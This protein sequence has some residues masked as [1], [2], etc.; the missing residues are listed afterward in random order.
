MKILYCLFL[1]QTY[2]NA[3]FSCCSSKTKETPKTELTQLKHHTKSQTQ[4]SYNYNLNITNK[5][6]LLINSIYES[7]INALSSVDKQGFQQSR[8]NTNDRI[9]KY[10]LN[11]FLS[12]F[13]ETITQKEHFYQLINPNYT[14]E[15]VEYILL[16]TNTQNYAKEIYEELKK[17]EEFKELIF[18]IL[19]KDNI[20]LFILDYVK[21]TYK[22][23][24]DQESYQM[25]VNYF[26]DI[27][28]FFSKYTL[29]I[30][31]IHQTLR[32]LGIDYR[33]NDQ[34]INQFSQHFLG[35]STQDIQATCDTTSITNSINIQ[36][37]A[38]DAF[39]RTCDGYLFFMILT[40]CIYNT[41][42]TCNLEAVRHFY[43]LYK[44][45]STIAI[46]IFV[47]K[48]RDDPNIISKFPQFLLEEG[49]NSWHFKFKQYA[50]NHIKT[51]EFNIINQ[52]IDDFLKNIQKA[53]KHRQQHIESLQIEQSDFYK[54]G[55]ELKILQSNQKIYLIR[56]YQSMFFCESILY[57]MG[58]FTPKY[59]K[60]CETI[61]WPLIFSKIK[62]ILNPLQQAFSKIYNTTYLTDIESQKKQ[63]LSYD[64]YQILSLYLNTI[65][66]FI[67]T[68]NIDIHYKSL[69]SPK[70]LEHSSS[71]T[72]Q[73]KH[74]GIIYL[75]I[76][77]KLLIENLDKKSYEYFQKIT[78]QI[79]IIEH[80]VLLPLYTL[81]LNKEI[82]ERLNI[83]A[84]KETEIAINFINYLKKYYKNITKEISVNLFNLRSMFVQFFQQQYP[85]DSGCYDNI[86][87]M[88]FFE[89]CIFPYSQLTK[90][91][92]SNPNIIKP[93]IFQN[94]WSLDSVEFQ[95]FLIMKFFPWSQ[96]FTFSE[97]IV[98]CIQNKNNII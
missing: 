10:V 4:K 93:I 20:V 7:F 91:L 18:N 26:K 45:A 36:C 50:S 33:R 67:A 97:Y 79:P 89:Y 32:F 47:H 5:Q 30:Q 27:E 21:D 25:D 73:L 54:S 53:F 42:T 38:T 80:S 59:L 81:L 56:N 86:I 16:K 69:I 3:G 96:I 9:K 63:N 88:S 34:Y 66:S 75:Q 68:K 87:L 46:T 51:H 1:T 60:I 24:F 65:Y 28:Q 90:K 2:S 19:I 17:S 95:N 15:F 57:L 61:N 58:H 98:F 70:P 72:I 35:I 74:N 77:Y 49:E 22:I 44:Q 85:S 71:N 31:L 64:I 13:A 92:E 40:N 37:N 43:Q 78:S 29:P 55:F 8:E 82:A 83:I 76:P 23:R 94:Q 52:N 39:T 6:S 41:H 11:N 12:L 62:Q 84:S 48:Y 14:K